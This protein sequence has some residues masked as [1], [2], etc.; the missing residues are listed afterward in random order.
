MFKFYDDFGYAV[1]MNDLYA[2]PWIGQGIATQD[3]IG[4]Y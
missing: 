2:A 4:P 3:Y 1:S